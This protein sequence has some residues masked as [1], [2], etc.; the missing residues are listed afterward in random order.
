MKKDIVNYKFLFI[1]EP[2]E[3]HPNN[4]KLKNASNGSRKM[5]VSVVRTR[6]AHFGGLF[7]FFH[8]HLIWSRVGPGNFIRKC[9]IIG[10]ILACRNPRSREESGVDWLLFFFAF[11]A[12]PATRDLDGEHTQRAEDFFFFFFPSF[13][14]S[15]SLSF[16]L[17]MQGLLS[18]IFSRCRK[19]FATVSIVAEGGVRC[20]T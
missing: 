7:V 13:P 9:S 6:T 19:P 1:Q 5:P 20:K 12:R 14:L 15:V 3:W 18:C 2:L 17:R 8:L 4:S 11:Q 10:K 16:L